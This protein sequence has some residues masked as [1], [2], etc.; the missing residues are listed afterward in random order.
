MI[1]PGIGGWRMSKTPVEE[2]IAEWWDEFP[3]R[4]RTMKKILAA[5]ES[6]LPTPNIDEFDE[7]KDAFLKALPPNPSNLN[8]INDVSKAWAKWLKDA[9]PVMDAIMKVWSDRKLEV[10]KLL[11]TKQNEL[12]K[13]GKCVE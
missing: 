2:A 3:N 7:L 4:V 6:D 8:S 11:A 12:L 10:Q 9:E 13:S 5:P 1:G